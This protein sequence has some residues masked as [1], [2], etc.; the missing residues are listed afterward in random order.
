MRRMR[1]E[2]QNLHKYKEV[3]LVC[4]GRIFFNIEIIKI[5]FVFIFKL[6]IKSL[7]LFF[8]ETY[9]FASLLMINSW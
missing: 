9:I 4:G 8:K 7:K 3:L 1:E 6:S 5:T 2:R